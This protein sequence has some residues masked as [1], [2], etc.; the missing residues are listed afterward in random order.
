MLLLIG[1]AEP[2]IQDVLSHVNHAAMSK[3][4]LN[5]SDRR[6][7]KVEQIKK[8]QPG[9]LDRSQLIVFQILVLEGFHIQLLHVPIHN[10][11]V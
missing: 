9:A 2:T 7:S 5:V 3:V 10:R 4:D 8:L 6:V 11:M 1:S